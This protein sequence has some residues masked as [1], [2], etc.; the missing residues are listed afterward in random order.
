MNKKITNFILTLIL[1]YILGLFLS[2]W[3]VMV[4]A[5]VTAFIFP[6]KKASIFFIPFLAIALLWIIQS[7]LLSS[8]NDYTLAKKIATLLPLGGNPFFLIAVTGIIGGVAAGIAA[9]FGK[10]CKLLINRF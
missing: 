7:W 6:L 2:W 8:V 4:A 10:Q 5:F 1:A 3:S 9:V